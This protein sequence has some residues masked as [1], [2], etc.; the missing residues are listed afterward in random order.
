MQSVVNGVDVIFVDQMNVTVEV[1][2][3]EVFETAGDPFSD[4]NS[5]NLFA[6]FR[7]AATEFGEWR[8]SEGGTVEASGLAHLFS[9]K[10]LG[11]TSGG[12]GF[13]FIG[14][15]CDA[16]RGVSISTTRFFNSVSFSSLILAH[17]IG[18][19]FGAPH[20]A[21][22]GACENAPAGFLMA[23]SLNSS[24]QFSQCSKDEMADDIAQ[25]EIV[26][27]ITPLPTVDMRVSL[28]GSD[29]TILLGNSATVT[30]DFTNAGAS[31]ATDVNVDITLPSNVS[32]VSA[33]ASVGSCTNGGGL[34]SCAI[35]I[36]NGSS[37]ASVVL[38]S[39]TTAV[40]VGTFDAT[41]T[42]DVDERAGN[43]QDTA[44][45]TVS[46]AVNLGVSVPPARQINVDQSA[47]VSVTLTNTSILDATGVTMS[48]SLSS[49]LRA[50]NASWS[51]GNCTVAA[52][53]IDCVATSF[54]AQSNS[55]FTVNVTGMTEGAK[56]V[57][58]SMSSVEAD[59]DP[60]N[61][62][63]S[64]TVNVGVV[65][66]DSGGGATG[67]LLLLF[68]AIIGSR[69]RFRDVFCAK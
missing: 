25:A 21:A 67:I 1:T 58:V 54:G 18:H 33:A 45:L 65:E 62:T 50:N 64:A 15:L 61:N 26:G 31:Q 6:N 40:G 47:T 16:D 41:V 17:E 53:Q 37:T 22:P 14:T 28:N 52:S 42:A 38:T 68:L 30:F 48:V 24:N 49:G 2:H 51:I 4:F 46:P 13:G 55:T 8:D 34:V 69:A 11:L 10:A 66:E 7:D 59:A 32:L 19:N 44:V 12:A 60:S 27:C 23:T 56:A 63:A 3:S 57:N 39:D 36:V 5:G 35:G 43:N 29:P 9:D 20:D